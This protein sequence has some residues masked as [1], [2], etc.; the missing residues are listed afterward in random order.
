M[1]TGAD[2]AALVAGAE[3]LE[4]LTSV[5]DPGNAAAAGEQAYPAGYTAVRG[6]RAPI[7]HVHVKDLARETAGGGRARFVPAAEGVIDYAGQ[8]AALATD[9]YRGVLSLEPHVGPGLENM[10]R[11]IAGLRASLAEAEKRLAQPS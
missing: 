5:W 4:R 7:S 11:C 6:T 1:A 8:L 3:G 2:T 10:R 9:G